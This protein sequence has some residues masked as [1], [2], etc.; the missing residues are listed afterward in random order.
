MISEYFEPYAQGGGE[1]SAFNLAK[2]LVKNKIEIHVLTSHFNG[3]KTKETI[4]NVKLFRYLSSGK[5][6]SLF[7]NV[8][9]IINFEKSVIKQLPKLYSKEKYDIIHCMNTN[10]IVAIKLKKKINAKFIMHVNGPVP[11]CPKGTLMYK[12]KKICD[13]KC[14]RLTYLDCFI[15]SKTAGKKNL[16]FLHKFN[17]LT[18]F[19]LRKNYETLNSLIKKFDYY[20]PISTY[21][22]NKLTFSGIPKNKTKIIYNILDFNKFS[23]LKQPKNKIKKILYLGA[24]SKSKGPQ[25]LLQA[26]SNLKVQ[27]TANFYGKG[28]LKEYLVKY[29]KSQ[30]LNVTINDKVDYKEI[31]KIIQEHDILVFPSLVG[32]AFGRVALEALAANKTVIASNIGGIPDVIQ[33]NKSGYLFEPGNSNELA[34][35][36]EKC[37]KENIKFKPNLDKFDKEKI[38]NQVIKI[39]NKK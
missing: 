3:L 18:M 7:G 8:K 14:T 24:Y 15:H 4:N 29:T 25:I 34:K 12:D 19:L 32:E 39:Y 27:Y 17:P 37:I 21:M 36:I 22:Q 38:V 11:F 30:K 23:K 10:S 1:I 6:N 28:E 35:L 33:H 9:R 31:P 26:L 13:K 20:M 16:N 5:P 2:E